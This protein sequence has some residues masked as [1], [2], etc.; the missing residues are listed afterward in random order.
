MC[1]LGG[2]C[3]YVGVRACVRA[4]CERTGA[5]GKDCRGGGGGARRDQC[6]PFVVVDHNRC[7]EYSRREVSL[8]VAGRRNIGG[9]PF[10]SL[11]GV[12]LY[13]CG[14]VDSP[15]VRV[16]VPEVQGSMGTL[17]VWARCWCRR[18]LHVA[19][20]YAVQMDTGAVG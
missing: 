20:V 9:L 4:C 8:K 16:W 2:L 3:V 10:I 18:C 19:A 12:A 7:S 17:A 5:T 14:W 1:D 15:L 6:L 13:V 11:L